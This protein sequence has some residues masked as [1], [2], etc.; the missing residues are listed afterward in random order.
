LKYLNVY[1]ACYLLTDATHFNAVQLV[2]RIQSYIAANL[3][4]MLEV[5]MLE[6]L[7]PWIMRQLCE[8]IR[9][10]QM[11]KS[12]V[13]RSNSLANEALQKHA[14]WLALQDIPVVLE[15]VDRPQ[16]HRDSPKL[17]PPSP[18]KPHRI[19]GLSS[20]AGP[21]TRN[22]TDFGQ[23]GDELFAMDE[24]LSPDR[25]IPAVTEPSVPAAVWKRPPSTPRY[26]DSSPI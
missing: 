10:A 9:G 3:K 8:Y 5:R 26:A 20:P 2:E 18:T 21:V 17:S 4:M 7:D 6:D 22:V 19:V 11:E 25:P 23:S 14:E 16:I 15:P 13:S 24:V 1:N 12:F